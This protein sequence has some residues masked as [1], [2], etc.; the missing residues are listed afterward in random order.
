VSYVKPAKASKIAEAAKTDNAI[1][2]TKPTRTGRAARIVE[3]S[4]AARA[5]ARAHNN[6]MSKR[7]RLLIRLGIITGGVIVIAAAI[8][9]IAG[10]Q[11][12]KGIDKRIGFDDVAKDDLA[13]V[14]VKPDSPDDPY[15][16]LLLGSDSR[17]DSDINAGRSDTIILARI[18]PVVPTVSLL[19]IPRDTMIELEGYGT[20]K[21]KTVTFGVKRYKI[22]FKS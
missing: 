19:S 10:S 9:L 11:Y 14:L 3:E 17:D 18:D 7:K 2:S 4:R 13:K 20:Q 21:I 12:L 1:S 15:Y 6:L 16:V 8:V 22:P 5:E